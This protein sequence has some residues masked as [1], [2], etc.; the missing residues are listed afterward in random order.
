MGMSNYPSSVTLPKNSTGCSTVLEFLI[1]K[2]SGIEP[3]IWLQRINDG[4]VQWE[5]KTP[6][7]EHSPYSP[8]K[9][10]LYYREVEHEPAI[11][12]SETIL[13]Q[14]DKILVADKPHFMPVIPNGNYVRQSLLYRLR[15]N[16]GID[17]LTPIHRIDR[18]T[19]GV[20]MFSINPDT[21][22]LYQMLFANGQITKT[23]HAI[24]NVATNLDL[25]TQQL[26][27]QWLVENRIVRGDPWFRMTVGDGKINAR[28]RIK[29]IAVKNTMGLFHLYPLTG[30]THQL[31]LHMSGLDMPLLNERYY[32]GLQPESEDDF[33][34]PLQLLAKRLEFVDPITAEARCFNSHMN[35][36]W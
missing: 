3:D 24:A 11:P 25:V 36:A 34:Q 27:R 4:K 7:S 21:R 28:T 2:F 12:F 1:K 9:R 35:L 10:V 26:P 23:Y 6:V 29:C 15:S 20:V 5:D 14:D 31:R 22:G 13:Y 16:T 30:K 17:T 33:K 32:P 18:C 19:A 8:H